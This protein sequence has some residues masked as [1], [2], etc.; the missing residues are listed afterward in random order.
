[1]SQTVKQL[2]PIQ[3]DAS[4]I[5]QVIERAAS[6]PQVDIEK[7]ERLLA[8]QERVMKRNA[9]M[10][11]NAALAEMQANM[12]VI[13]E[14]GE[15]KVGDTVRSRYATFEDINEAIKPILQTN[16][17]AISFRTSV[18]NNTV[19]VTGVLAHRSGHS[20]E[21]SLPLATDTSG[22]KNA[23]QAIGSSVQYGKRYVMCAL[24][25]ITSRGEDDDGRRA[26]GPE[27]I[28]ASQAA[29]LDSLIDEVGADRQKFMKYLRLT[30]LADLPAQA[31]KD[32]VAAL[33]KKRARS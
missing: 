4:A 21:T 31:F 28:S 22:S 16:G 18:T 30:N 25:N 14:R 9:E 6:N 26:A 23:V 24:L 32:A 11:F 2:A 15:I 8:M 20:I 12:P 5:I 33:E 1:M 27:R 17:F 10:D 13:S 7:M 3:S 19:T 29:D